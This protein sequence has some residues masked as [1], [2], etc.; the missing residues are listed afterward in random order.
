MTEQNEQEPSATCLDVPTRGLEELS[1]SVVSDFRQDV[2]DQRWRNALKF[3]HGLPD[4]NEEKAKA[5][6]CQGAKQFGIWHLPDISLD[7]LLDQLMERESQPSPAI[8]KLIQSYGSATESKSLAATALTE[9]LRKDLTISWKDVEHYKKQKR[10][11]QSTF[12]EGW[13]ATLV[14]LSVIEKMKWALALLVLLISNAYALKVVLLMYPKAIEVFHWPLYVG[15]MCGMAAAL[16]TMILYWSMAR[17]F[18]S[19]MYGCH[20]GQWAVA[21]LDGHKDIHMFAGIALTVVGVVHTAAHLLGTVPGLMSATPEDLNEVLGCANRNSTDGFINVEMKSLQWPECPITKESKPRTVTQALTESMPG[22]TGLLLLLLLGLTYRTAKPPARNSN[23]ERFSY[24]HAVTIFFWPVLLFLHGS[25]AW[26]G[27]G[28]PLVVFTCTLPVSLYLM[29]RICRTIRF[30]CFAGKSVSIVKATVRR[31]PKGSDNEKGALTYLQINPP[32]YLWRFRPGMYAFLCMPEYARFQWHPFTI[33]SGKD[34]DTVDF[35]IEAVGD[36]TQ[37][38]AKRCLA[39][40]S[41][42]DQKLPMVALDGPYMAPTQ[43]ALA[44]KVLIAVGAGVG[45]T[46]FLSLMSSIISSLEADGSSSFTQLREVHFFWLTKS[47][48]EFLFGRKHFSKLLQHPQ[49][50]Q[51]VFMHLHVTYQAKNED[52][53]AYTFREAVRRQSVVDRDA[54]RELAKEI[55]GKTS[56]L[57]GPT[58]PWCWMDGARND[59]LWVSHLVE[60]QATEM[61]RIRTA[62][63]GHWGSEFLHSC[64][65][66]PSGE[67]IELSNEVAGFE[68][69]PST[70]DAPLDLLPI[71]F[72]RP[73]WATEVRSI[74]K[75]CPGKNIHLY[76]CGPAKLVE[77]LQD[78]AVVCNQ[79][80]ERDTT[81]RGV[82]Q[83]SYIVHF[84]RFG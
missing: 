5:V 1:N 12:T 32:P 51:M 62:H 30:Y 81:E 55:Q 80:A 17:S 84:E 47:A 25:N 18:L 10:A 15:R 9:R 11:L 33:C 21:P 44:K 70:S 38:L 39:A 34:D 79:H 60:Q 49:L 56:K 8:Q 57:V 23:F 71:V 22:V 2:Q 31:A 35:L 52:P 64:R 68:A 42:P 26:V 65:R 43:S 29:D 73:D 82:A 69:R 13:K 16:C 48:D 20:F 61:K 14:D 27:V 78:V 54:F 53:M 83:Q 75:S 74:G 4:W 40:Q 76:V 6:L 46:P 50:K 28:L 36:W 58:L 63:T 66:P 24:V 77:E 37:E 19:R 67:S 72:G 45:I 3:L 7:G 59:L 41:N